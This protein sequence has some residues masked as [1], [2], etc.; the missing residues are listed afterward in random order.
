MFKPRKRPA[1]VGVEVAFL[2][3]QNFVEGLVDEGKSV[4]DRERLAPGIKHL[5]VAGEHGHAR[6]DGRLGEVD[7]GDVAPLEMGQ[8]ERQLSLERGY[9][10]A[11]GGRRRIGCALA[12]YENDA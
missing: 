3:C 5:G 12:A 10:V 4:P 1:A 9:E 11:T 6:A 8:R 2:L 7:G